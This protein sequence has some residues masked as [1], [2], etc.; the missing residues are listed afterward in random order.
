VDLAPS[1][2]TVTAAEIAN[3]DPLDLLNSVAELKDV[4]ITA[5][6]LIEGTEAI[7]ALFA[8][9]LKDLADDKK[10]A[11]LSGLMKAR[12]ASMHQA[13]TKSPAKQK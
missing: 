6:E 13:S 7:G 12:F 9:L 11:A 4:K 3:T 8:S 2:K 5:E 10:Q 1:G